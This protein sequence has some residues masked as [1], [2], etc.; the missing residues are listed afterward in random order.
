VL[1]AL[2]AFLC[3]ALLALVIWLSPLGIYEQRRSWFFYKN[4]NNPPCNDDRDCFG[5]ATTRCPPPDFRV[6][7]YPKNQHQGESVCV[8]GGT[9]G[10]GFLAGVNVTEELEYERLHRDAGTDSSR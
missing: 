1:H 7:C 3:L 8:C 10:E 6:A 4:R 9:V 2:V 5:F